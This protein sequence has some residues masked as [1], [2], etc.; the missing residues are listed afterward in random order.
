[1]RPFLRNDPLNDMKMRETFPSI[2]TM[3]ITDNSRFADAGF[4][5]AVK[6]ANQTI[7]FCAVG[8]HHQNG[9]VKQRIKELTLISCT[10]LLHAKQHWPDYITTMM[11]PFALKEAAFWLNRLSLRSDGRS[12]KATFFNI[13][14]DLFYLTTLHIFGSPCFVL[15]SRLQSGIAGP[16]KWEPRSRLGI[17]VGH[18]PSH[19][20]LVAL[21]LNPRTGHISPQFHVVFD[22]LFTTVPYMKKSEL[23]PNWAEL[24]EKSSERVTDEDYDLAKTWFFPDAD[25]GDIAMQ[26]IN[27]SRT[28]AGNSGNLVQTT[29][30]SE[31]HVLPR[32]KI[33]FSRS[34]NATGISQEDSIPCPYLDSVTD[35]LPLQDGLLAP[36][37]INLETSGL[38]QSP[39]IL[40][41][42]NNNNVLAIAAN[43]TSTMPTSSRQIA[44]PRQC[45]SFLLVFNL[46]GSLCTFATTNS[47]TDSETFSLWPVSQMTLII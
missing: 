47:H 22:D 11:W 21:F 10:L 15:D 46:V 7:T 44:R 31:H 19:A 4:Q 45:L 39:R 16:P 35:S 20:G 14:K 36:T 2:H 27:N 17:Y 25:S 43:T 30:P 8:A 5:K 38:Q 32:H 34:N 23:P 41:L 1:M 3:Q 18:S 29:L 9:I 26:E 12:Y 42:N 6:E 28:L 37:L 24:V 40:A 33:D 13:D